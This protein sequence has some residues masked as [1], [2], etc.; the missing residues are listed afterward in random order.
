MIR[1]RSILPIDIP[2]ERRRRSDRT[3]VVD[4]LPTVLNPPPRSSHRSSHRLSRPLVVAVIEFQLCRSTGEVPYTLLVVAPFLAATRTPPPPPPLTRYKRGGYLCPEWYR[5]APSTA[6]P[7][8]G[9]RFT[10]SSTLSG[11]LVSFIPRL[12]ISRS[13]RESLITRRSSIKVP[14]ASAHAPLLLRGR[15]TRSRAGR[16]PSRIEIRKTTLF[17]RD[18]SVSRAERIDRG[19]LMLFV[20]S[21]SLSYFP[22]FRATRARRRYSLGDDLGETTD[23]AARFAWKVAQWS[24]GGMESNYREW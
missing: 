16:S 9:I 2:R 3:D 4:L 15:G 1:L 19:R 11:P 10:G 24:C 18:N 13:C 20:T 21:R 23:I 6:I 22:L 7:C 5:R 12:R 14:A 17:T 8:T